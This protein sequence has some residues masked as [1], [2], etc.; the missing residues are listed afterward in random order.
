[1]SAVEAWLAGAPV[2]VYEQSV[3]GAVCVLMPN[4]MSHEVSFSLQVRV[5]D[6]I[7]HWG[8]SAI[9]ETAPDRELRAGAAKAVLAPATRPKKTVLKCMMVEG[10]F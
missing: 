2:T 7:V 3:T 6:S 9:A 8:T 4:E 1:M 10:W 5:K